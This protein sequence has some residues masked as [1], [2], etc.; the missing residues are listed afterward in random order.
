[1]K[2]RKNSL[3]AKLYNFTY[4]SSLPDSLCPYFWKLV[5]AVI[6]FIPNFILQLPALIGTFIFKSKEDDSFENRKTGLAIYVVLVLVTCFI[7][8]NV[9]FTKCLLLHAYNKEWLNIAV[10]CDLVVIIVLIGWLF[11]VIKEQYFIFK[12]KEQY[13]IFKYKKS[14]LKKDN[15]ITE[16][17]K[18]KYNKYCP[19]I[20]WE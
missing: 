7:I 15:I 9:H 3:H 1:M 4:N 18:A 12:Y 11:T 5:F 19:K 8:A 20:E 2:A 17:I 10:V 16:Y 14:H 6:M 13:F